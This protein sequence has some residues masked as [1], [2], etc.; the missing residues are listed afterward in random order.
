MVLKI[1]HKYIFDFVLLLLLCSFSSVFANSD[2]EKFKLAESYEKSGDLKNASRLYF[3]LYIFN[4]H[5][6]NY[7]DAV[8]R[9]YK[10]QN[11][12]SELLPIVEDNLKLRQFSNVYA[13]YGE[14]L[15]KLG[16]SNEANKA[17]QEALELNPENDK[18]YTDVANTQI[19]C[20]LYEKA[21]ATLL[22][23]RNTLRLK[24][25]F[26]DELS[27]LYTMMGN[28]KDA[29]S[30]ILSQFESTRNTGVAQ[31]RFN[32]LFSIPEAKNYIYSQLSDRAGSS[33]DPEYKRLYAWY[34][35]LLGKH[36]EAFTIY[37]KID[38]MLKTRGMEV[39]NFATSSQKDGN[40]DI[41]LKAYE[42]IIDKG[43]SGPY[44]M[45]ALFGFARTLESKIQ[46]DS[47]ISKETVI[48]VINRYRLVVKDF[49]QTPTADDALF[50]I[51]SLYVE[52]L[53]DNQS[54]TKALNE[55]LTKSPG[56]PIAASALLLL[57][58][59]SFR[60]DNPKAA[61]DYYK[62]VIGG[63]KFLSPNEYVITQYRLAEL[64]YFS[65]DIDSAQVHFGLISVNSRADI[66]N[67]ALEKVVLIEENKSLTSAMQ[68][69]AI[70]EKLEK[71]KRFDEALAKYTETVNS[72]EGSDLA[73]RSFIKIARINA[74]LNRFPN[75]RIAID[76]LLSK[77]PKTIYAD[78]AVFIKA[79]SYMSEKN[80]EVALKEFTDFLA[81]YP[82]SIY[83]DEV[84][85]KIRILRKDKL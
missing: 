35:R 77:Y 67:D 63:Y 25:M 19:T 46:S 7:F 85:E 34:L 68:T 17:W 21:I 15:W 38:D 14:I 47:G 56:K 79:N 75:S 4:K 57:G 81:I 39:L 26:A 29:T 53:D 58:D 50:R 70:G 3:E 36:E 2:T 20:R 55:L 30:E 72:A 59:I 80:K 71:L 31:G 42:Y 1:R 23:A 69:Y 73:E 52:Q 78:Y 83:L 22:K 12:Y 16:K 65:G 41:A 62:K 54:A 61:E 6:E 33:N 76:S 10:A 32:A 74:N 11:L 18:A 9:T 43:K 48:G 8:V 49:Y 66:A 24:T 84:R 5:N 82:R 40:Y 37:Q 13:L 27:Q 51:A 44:I 45:N 64:E 28:Y 60:S